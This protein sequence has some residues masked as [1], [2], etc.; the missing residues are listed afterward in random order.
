MWTGGPSITFPPFSNCAGYCVNTISVIH[1][2]DESER[3]TAA[4]KTEL[5]QH[6]R[7]RSYSRSSVNPP[8]ELPQVQAQFSGYHQPNVPYEWQY[9]EYGALLVALP[10]F[11]IQRW[12][13][14]AQVF[15]LLR[16]FGYVNIANEPLT[17]LLL[18]G[19]KDLPDDLNKNILKLTP[20][21]IHETGRFD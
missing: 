9:R 19:D 6:L 11:K 7:T 14:L 15:A 5:H 3:H 1:L 13:L 2:I 16:P 10:S 12:N 17:H 4:R 18:Y 8:V 20:E 21:F